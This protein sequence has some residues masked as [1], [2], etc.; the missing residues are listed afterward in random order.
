MKG[1]V[2]ETAGAFIFM[3]AGNLAELAGNGGPVEQQG[4]FGQAEAGAS[5][6]KS[7][8]GQGASEPAE[9]LINDLLRDAAEQAQVAEAG[10]AAKFFGGKTDGLEN[11]LFGHGD[12]L[13][14]KLSVG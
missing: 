14:G 3:Y 8:G 4:G 12:A 1:H 6:F 9:A 7:G 11:P 13:C 5:S 2:A 10:V